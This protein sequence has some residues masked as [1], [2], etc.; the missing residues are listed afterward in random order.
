MEAECPWDKDGVVIAS[1]L[2]PAAMNL[3]KYQFTL[4][5]TCAA[6]SMLLGTLQLAVI[7]IPILISLKRDGAGDEWWRAVLLV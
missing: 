6:W 1:K 2:Q 4:V 3:R 5:L 7:L